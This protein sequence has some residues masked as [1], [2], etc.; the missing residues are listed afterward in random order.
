MTR[1]YD[2]NTPIDLYPVY[3]SDTI[4]AAVKRLAGEISADYAGKEVL[5]V[6]VLQGAF[7]FAADLA[8]EMSI[9]VT[10]DFVRI[11]SYEGM[12]S[13]GEPHLRLDVSAPLQGRHVV[14]VEDIVDTGISL[15]FLLRALQA[16]NPASLRTCVLIDKREQRRVDVQ[17]DYHGI[18]CDHGF[19][20]GYGLD[21]NGSWRQLPDIY[22]AE[23]QSGRRTE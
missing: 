6:V 2:G 1:I 8:R 23:P 9:P 13:T 7:I 20:I 3:T 16:R 15:S 19:L 11:A 18:I 5:L 17:V 10:F 4:A 21:L 22:H 12:Q 14:V